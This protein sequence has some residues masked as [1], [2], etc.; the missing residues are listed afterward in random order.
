MAD[1]QS[2]I[3]VP[4]KGTRGT[5]VLDFLFGLLRP[6]AGGEVNRY[7]KA[8]GGEQSK[9]RGF[10]VL[11][12][13]TVGA[14]SGKE[15]STVLG[16]FPDGDESWLI[17]AS[18]GG[19]ATNPGWLHNIAANPDKVWVEVG[20]RRIHVRV[21]SLRGQEREDAYARVA[22]AAPTYAGYPKKTDREISVLRVTSSD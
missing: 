11:I 1:L 12:L 10:P 7:R 16:G 9:F 3:Q 4:P 5:R 21:A 8:A 18:Q 13:T 6:L 19:S 20:S 14:R 2:R 15:R 17:V 22:K